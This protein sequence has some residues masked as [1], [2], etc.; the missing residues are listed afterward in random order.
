MY[1]NSTLLAREHERRFGWS[2]ATSASWPASTW[3]ILKKRTRP[4]GRNDEKCET[5]L[6]R[7]A[8][9]IP[10]I[11]GTF[12]PL[13]PMISFDRG[14]RVCV[15][16]PAAAVAPTLMRAPGIGQKVVCLRLF[17]SSLGCSHTACKIH[18]AVSG[19][20]PNE[21]QEVAAKMMNAIKHCLTW[22]RIAMELFL[23]G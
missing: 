16:V 20:G 6:L 12:M 1:Q 13:T 17:R 10:N 7:L 5:K 8:C 21:N 9:H 15:C 3:Q 22:T 4:V 14:R 11:S 23:Q 19:V 2:R 18:A